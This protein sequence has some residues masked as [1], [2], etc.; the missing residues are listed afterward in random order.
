MAII[1]KSVNSNIKKK[2]NG[3][4]FRSS[5][6]PCLPKRRLQSARPICQRTRRR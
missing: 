3:V 1:V 5:K 2:M 4:I 6:L